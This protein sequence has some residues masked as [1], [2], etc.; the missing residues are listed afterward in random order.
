MTDV[1]V[2]VIEHCNCSHEWM[3]SWHLKREYDVDFHRCLEQTQQSNLS[4]LGGDN[5]AN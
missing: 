1:F 5:A 2:P 3:S 4:A